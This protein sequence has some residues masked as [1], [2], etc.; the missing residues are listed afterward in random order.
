MKTLLKT[1]AFAAVFSLG[2]LAAVDAGAAEKC[3]NEKGQFAK[4]PDAAPAKATKCR[5]IKSKKF[6]SCS[7]PGTEPVPV[8]AS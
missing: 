5:D 7:A 1:L 6:A 8:K 2:A 3:R 4:C